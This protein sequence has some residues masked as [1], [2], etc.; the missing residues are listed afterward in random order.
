MGEQ[1]G[2]ESPFDGV[3]KDQWAAMLKELERQ[4]GKYLP[5]DAGEE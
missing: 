4:Y 1:A 3:T 5:P 2:V